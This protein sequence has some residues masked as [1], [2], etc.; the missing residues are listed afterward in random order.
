MTH[1]TL[2]TKKKRKLTHFTLSFFFF[3]SLVGQLRD[4]DNNIIKQ[5]KKRDNN[6]RPAFIDVDQDNDFDLF[7]GTHEDCFEFYRNVG[8]ATTAIF[9]KESSLPFIKELQDS[10][11]KSDNKGGYE[12]YCQLATGNFDGDALSDIITACWYQRSAGKMFKQSVG[13]VFTQ[14]SA[15]ATQS[16]LPNIYAHGG[17]TF[18]DVSIIYLYCKN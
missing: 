6:N 15:W 7:I 17:L 9:R 11:V 10:Y 13:S 2:K 16:K 12:S 1:F 3:L 5:N 4:E 8:T 14:S 18:G